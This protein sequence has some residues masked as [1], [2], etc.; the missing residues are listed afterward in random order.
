MNT[1]PPNQKITLFVIDHRSGNMGNI[2]ATV[3]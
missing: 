2:M 1:L 3:K